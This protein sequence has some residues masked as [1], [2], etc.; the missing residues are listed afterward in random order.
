M[1]SLLTEPVEAPANEQESNHGTGGFDDT[2][3]TQNTHPII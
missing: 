1:K 3:L 2:H